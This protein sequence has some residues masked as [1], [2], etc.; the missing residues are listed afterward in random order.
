MMFDEGP[1]VGAAHGHYQD[2]MNP[3]Y[4]KI[5]VGLFMVSGHMYLTNDYSE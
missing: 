4:R 2:M 3:K 5:G 1:G